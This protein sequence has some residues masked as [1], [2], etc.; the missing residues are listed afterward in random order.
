MRWPAV[1]YAQHPWTPQFEHGTA[2]RSALRLHQGPYR[3]AVVPEISTLQCSIDSGVVAESTDAAQEIA[4]FDAE[5]G[6]EIAPFTTVLLR[7]E[8]A[9]SSQIENLTASA[10]AIGEATLGATGS[11]NARLVV[12]NVQAMTAALELADE[13]ST[14]NVLAMHHALLYGTD[15]QQ[16]GHIRQQQV[17]IGGSYL[18]PHLAEFVPPHHTDVTPALDDL[19]KFCRRTDLPVLVHVAIAHAQFETIHPFTDGNGRTGRAL[20]HSM[21]KR[22]GLVRH[23]TVPLSAGLLNRVDSYYAALNAYRDGEVD[24]IIRC[25]TDAAFNA[26]SNG[27]LL[28]EQLREIRR[29]WDSRIK[30]NRNSRAWDVADLVLRSPVLNAQAISSALGIAPSSVYRLIQPLLDAEVLVDSRASRRNRVWRSPEVLRAVD[31]FAAR[32]TRRS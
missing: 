31:Q 24:K 17:W 1:Q 16:A 25:F 32:S 10:R 28:V 7:S 21:L 6:Q 13:I 26:V 2:S 23:V 8:S 15:P 14:D 22:A 30:A 9:A 18:G 12:A 19:M 27:R 11:S 4:R 29:D 5:L 20:V 3:A